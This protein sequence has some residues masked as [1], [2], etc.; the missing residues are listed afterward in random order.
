MKNTLANLLL[1]GEVK[2]GLL[3]KAMEAKQ[4]VESSFEDLSERATSAVEAFNTP[5]DEDPVKEFTSNGIDYVVL[6]RTLTPAQITKVAAKHSLRPEA[7]QEIYASSLNA[8]EGMA[9]VE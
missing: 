4:A 1:A 3:S 9:E 7:V 6:P 8:L 5:Q 2:Y